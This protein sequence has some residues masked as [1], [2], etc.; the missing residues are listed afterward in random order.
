MVR[1]KDSSLAKATRWNNNYWLRDGE[2]DKICVHH[3]CGKLSSTSCGDYFKRAGV[4][5]NYGIGYK[6]DICQ[7]VEEKYGAYAQGTKYWNKRCISIECANDGKPGYHVSKATIDACIELVADICKRH[8]WVRISFTGDTKG[9]LIM[10]KYVA[11]T[12]CPGPYLST[13]FEYIAKEVNKIL[14]KS[15][16]LPERGYFK[17]G[18]KSPQVKKLKAFLK[19]K[20]YFKG[21]NMN[22]TY[23]SAMV[24]AVKR[25]EKD[26]GLTVDGEW[27]EKCNKQYDRIINK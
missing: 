9:R 23:S 13:K 24:K 17:K 26:Y 19:K 2:P 25:F 7:Y 11:N 22:S 3:M 20:G 16:F 4:S 18:D 27:G 6:G 14:D 15:I 5:S 8:G 21:R 1:K 10:H 12:T